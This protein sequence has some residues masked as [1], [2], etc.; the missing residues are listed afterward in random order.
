MKVPY[1]WLK[2]FVDI[3]V[4]PEVLADKLV[5]A[6]FEVED[7]ISEGKQCKNVVTGR[8]EEIVPHPDSDHMVICQLNVGE[9]DLV[10]IVTGA[11]NVSVGD[12]VPV[13]MHN[14]YLPDGTNIKKGKLRGVASYGMLCSGGELNLTEE[15]FNGAGV[16]GILQLDKNLSLGKDINEVIGKNDV[17]LD[18]AITANRPDCNSIIGVAR[19]VAAVL[20][21]P[22]KDVEIGY[23]ED[24]TDDISNYVDVSVQSE[25]CNHY[26]AKAVKDVVIKPSP[27]YIQ[28]RLT[29]C[30]IRPIN[31]IVDFTNYV[32][33][34]IGQPMHAFDEA[35]L[36]DK[37]IIVRQAKNGEVLVTLDGAENKLDE[38]M[39]VI[40]DKTSPVAVAGIMG[41]LGSGIKDSTKAVVFES[42]KFARDSVRR[43]SRKLKLASDSSQRY[44]KGIDY[45]SQNTAIDRILTLIYQTES[46]KIV[47]GKREYI[48]KPN[49]VRTVE[50]TSSEITKILGIEISDEEIIRLMQSLQFVISKNADKFV[51]EI[52]L[53]RQDVINANDVAE[54]LIRMHGYDHITSTLFVNPSQTQG[55]KTKYQQFEDKLKRVLCGMG[56]YEGISY[57]FIT[58]KAFDML[59]LAEDD[60]RRNAIKL[61]NPLGEDLSVMRTT[62]VHSMIQSM[63]N[64]LSKSVNKGRIFEIARTYIPKEFPIENQPNEIE[65][66]VIGLFGDSEDFFTTK[67]V[68]ENILKVFNVDAKYV[69]ASETYL[70]DG[71][72]A[73]IVCGKNV[74]GK[75]GEVHPKVLANYEID[76]RVYVIEIELEK[77]FRIKKDFRPFVNIPKYPSVDRDIAVIVNKS[78]TAEDIIST[79]KK[80]GGKM[81]ED[82]DI[83]DVYTSS[84]IGDDNKS[85]AISMV[86]RLE[87]RTLTEEVINGQ[88]E[89]ILKALEV[90]VGAKLR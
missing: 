75:F 37:T 60:S 84:S 43:T 41:G 80:T 27:N 90:R 52:P 71:R 64:N 51:C 61:L 74:I 39:L 16:Y 5:S 33:L 77:L 73:N 9:T 4:T 76:Q 62:L 68:V 59:C 23:E 29:A 49:V 8:I 89:R 81:L 88:I 31:N 12:V 58:P 13:A 35:E 28:K 20:N 78:V 42:A 47:G 50:F 21:K 32:L 56:I 36:K 18:V 25:N 10:Q 55:G 2:D 54:E 11:S 17:I 63:A 7:I 34:E 87:D 66:L 3:D 85:V 26:I 86:F 46:G 6:G 48:D 70:H 15:D 69:R 14:S 79:V 45:V 24:N 53:Y 57:S 72:S 82:A 83:F 40:C 67:G 44:E 30:G 22:F 19:E 65:N 1:S 38:S